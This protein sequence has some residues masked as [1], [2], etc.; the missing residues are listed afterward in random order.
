MLWAKHD[1]RKEPAE[2]FTPY[3]V[4]RTGGSKRR[5]DPDLQIIVR[6]FEKNATCKI[7][8]KQ[9]CSKKALY[10][11]DGSITIGKRG[12][13]SAT[14]LLKEWLHSLL[15]QAQH[16]TKV[17]FRVRETARKMETSSMFAGT[18][19]TWRREAAGSRQDT[20]ECHRCSVRYCL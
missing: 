13:S 7:L 12:V 10:G 15:K 6:V 3:G 5:M 18:S 16:E 17:A 20:E 9:A 11:A 8:L 4:H 2:V 14:G 1:N 19:C